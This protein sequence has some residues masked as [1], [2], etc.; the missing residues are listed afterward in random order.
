[1]KITVVTSQNVEI[2]YEVAS[3]GDRILA[4]LIDILIFVGLY[5]ATLV[6]LIG[7]GGNY[8]PFI[9]AVSI[10]GILAFIYRPLCEI[11]MNGQTIGKRQRNIRVVMLDGSSPT[12]GAYL[13]RWIVGFVDSFALIGLVVMLVNGKG[14]RLGDLAAGTTV[15]KLKDEDTIADTIHIVLEENYIPVFPQVTRL[16]DHD[17]NTIKEVADECLAEG[18]TSV[19]TALAQRIRSVLGIESPLPPFEL[20]TTVLKDYNYYTGRV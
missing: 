2:A 12:I 11:L 8:R 4:I 14:Q 7:A 3:V 1:M 16:T 10:V 15:V 17:M 5:L 13:L 20:V 9:I 19:L 6:L 18:N